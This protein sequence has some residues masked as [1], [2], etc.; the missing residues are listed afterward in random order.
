MIGS[1][2]QNFLL[3][4]I[5]V[6]ILAVVS[7]LAPA[8][9]EA[10]DIKGNLCGGSGFSLNSSDQCQGGSSL[11]A[12]GV[13]VNAGG[14]HTPGKCQA[15]RSFSDLV[16]LVINVLSIVVGII[17]VIMVI[18]GGFKFITSGGDSSKVTSARNTIIYAIIGLII[19]ALA[20]TI[21]KFVLAKT[22][23]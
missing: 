22:P 7:L 9:A 14:A 4:V 5:S 12:D 3:A 13:C 19:V 23:G 10:Q 2:K 16:T 17:A 20:Q 11:N 1:I 15:E 8:P 6:F 18:W 21:V